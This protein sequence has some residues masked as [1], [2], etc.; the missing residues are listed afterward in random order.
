MRKLAEVVALAGLVVLVGLTW[1]ALYGPHRLP[2]RVPTHFDAAGTP[3]A[4][5]SP[6]GMILLPAIA[7]GV[8]LLMSLVARYP[9]AFNYPVRATPT[10]LPRLQAIALRMIA[11]IKAE[12]ACLFA[13]LQGVFIQ[14]A[15]SGSGALFAKVLPVFLVVIF[16][17]VALHFIALFRAARG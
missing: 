2:D 15:R 3:N 8:Y 17:T 16:G 7:I 13:V 4:W 6:A 1:S 12:V 10:N 5:G 11:W 14:S 9:H